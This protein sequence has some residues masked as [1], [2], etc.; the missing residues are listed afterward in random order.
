MADETRRV[1]TVFTVADRA[2]RPMAHLAAQAGALQQRL[3]VARS[4]LAGL[5][6][7]SAGVIGL[8][9]GFGFLARK[10]F[11]AFEQAD[12]LRDSLTTLRFISKEMQQV[13][14]A[15]RMARSAELA[16]KDFATLET[17]AVEGVASMQT[18]AT[19]YKSLLPI[20]DRAKVSQERILGLVKNMVPVMGSVSGST[21]EAAYQARILSFAFMGFAAGRGLREF[22]K[23][24]GMTQ[25]QFRALQKQG[26]HKMFEELERR[27]AKTGP[28]MLGLF[29]DASDYVNRMREGV[30]VMWTRLS[31]P[32]MAYAGEQARRMYEWFLKN[33]ET[34]EQTA[35][36][37]GERIVVAMKA[38][39]A[40]LHGM[41]PIAKAFIA[42][43]V[44]ARFL[45]ALRSVGAILSG[46]TGL[47]A[48]RWSGMFKPH[49]A[50]TGEPMAMPGGGAW[51]NM[52]MRNVGLGGALAFVGTVGSAVGA[53]AG[54]A[55]AAHS[56][57]VALGEVQ[58]Q[59][60]TEEWK[61][62]YAASDA[63][64]RQREKVQLMWQYR[65]GGRTGRFLAAARK[66]Y[67]KGDPLSVASVAAQMELDARERGVAR[68]RA[69][70][71]K[72]DVHMDFRGSRFDIKQEFAE[73]FD[74]D[75]V[76]VAMT[77]DLALLGERRIQSPLA[78]LYGVR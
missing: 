4:R 62:R 58:V 29:R 72:A 71:E 76:A 39:A 57:A 37:W 50:Q 38:T 44:G 30:N 54:L 56:A 32:V 10:V 17:M 46:T 60:A 9:V 12:K 5:A 51:G 21:E 27:L 2:T 78:G 18:Y 34:V 7:Q 20:M 63:Q 24:L 61:R 73:G 14:P 68:A 13:D 49:F 53:I 52:G 3:T 48:Q 69:I 41:L 15:Q 64:Q 25:Q 47:L 43:W 70:A 59:E 36:V 66:M 42:L 6:M 11:Q 22:L 33:R 19:A 74:P 8:G 28:Q 45:G 65:E 1:E 23:V 31:E 26:P 67:P 16:R 75:R 77:T 40:A 35:K 55:L